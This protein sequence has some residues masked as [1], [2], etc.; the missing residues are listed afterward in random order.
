MAADGSDQRLLAALPGSSVEESADWQALPAPPVVV[1]PVVP[2]VVQPPVVQPPAIDI[3]NGTLACSYVPGTHL[4]ARD[5]D[6]D[7]LSDVRERRLRTSRARI[8]RRD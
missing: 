5:R 4:C 1:P 8:I 3:G 7:G 6:R 2:P